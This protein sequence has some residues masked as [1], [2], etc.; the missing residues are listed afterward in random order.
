[1][2]FY[3]VRHGE[4]TANLLREFS[5]S[6]TRH[7]LTERGVEQARALARNLA[8]VPFEIM[9]A[10]PILR[11]RQTAQI[12]AEELHAPVEVTEALREWSVG[13][14]EG[15][16]GPEGWEWHRRVQ[17]DWYFHNRPESRM[18]GGESFVEVR[19][20]F[21]PF[22]EG[23]IQNHKDTNR[24]ILCV[25][26]GGIYTAM[27]PVLFE[28]IDHAFVIEK[29]VAH[30]SPIIAEVRPAGLYCTTWCDTPVG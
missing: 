26:H 29:G 1:M 22:I 15:T 14:Y 8:G 3:F 25:A 17:E 24:N 27:L 7:P 2:K 20:R 23:L 13:I 12:V 5:N 9:Y 18:P 28:N 16:T 6:G 19:E 10:S 4:S 11:A 30:T 21:I